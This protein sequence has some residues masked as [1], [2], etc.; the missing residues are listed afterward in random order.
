M[1]NP[2][3]RN[4]IIIVL[5]ALLVLIIFLLVRCRQPVPVAENRPSTPTAA[6]AVPPPAAAAP[7]AKEPDEV[8]TPAT[9]Q[10]PLQVGAGSVFPVT[11]TGPDNKG[12]Y[13]TIVRQDAPTGTSGS[14]RLTREGRA[15]ELTAPIEP[16]DCEVRYVTG[17]SQTI[18]GRAPVTVTP[19]TATLEAPAEAT[20]GT[21]LTVKW[22]GPN[23]QG[24]FVTIVPK[25]KPDGQYENYTYAAKGSP[26]A[27][28]VPILPGDAELRYMTGQGN[29]VIARRPL[30]I[31]APEVSLSAPAETVAGSNLNVTWT[32]PNNSGDFITI[33]PKGK[34]DGQYGNYTYTAKGSPL[35]VLVPIMTGD[36]ELRYMTGQGNKVLARRPLAIIAAEVNLSAPAETIAGSNLNVTWTGPNNQGDFIA[37]APNGKPDGQYGNYTYTAKGSPLIVLV[38]IMTGDAELRYMTGQGSKVIARRPLTIVAAEITLS[39][40]AEVAAGSAVSVTWTGPNN[41]GDFIT[42]VLKGKPDNQFGNYAYTNKGSPLTVVAPKETGEAEVRYL[43]GQGNKVLLRRPIRITH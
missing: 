16:G 37:I 42:V 41:A 22:T 23:N 29:K 19:I 3:R 34:P 25:G 4:V 33:A 39:A 8:L 32:G 2:S 9:V 27:V 26:L 7:A 14:Y 18:L 5:L 10:A 11:W 15:L 28:L 30:T 24:D 13:V 17:R 35:I 6:A 12:D 1:S 40:P 38:P 36:A 21:T 20:L 43:A 31:I